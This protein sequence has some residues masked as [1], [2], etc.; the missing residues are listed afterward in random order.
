MNTQ[1]Q[2]SNDT[3]LARLLEEVLPR[4]SEAEKL[5]LWIFTEALVDYQEDGNRK[6]Y[7]LR[8]KVVADSVPKEKRR[9]FYK[10]AIAVLHE[11]K[12]A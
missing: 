8:C 1:S 12:A 10:N 3:E 4:L 5:S 11:K 6:R 9:Q 7:R 2:P